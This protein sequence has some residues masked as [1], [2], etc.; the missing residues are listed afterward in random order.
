[1]NSLS[2]VSAFQSCNGT[3][4]VINHDPKNTELTKFLS[5][6][7]VWHS[8]G[9][10]KPDGVWFEAQI[11]FFDLLYSDMFKA[12]LFRLNAVAVENKAN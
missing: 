8:R 5:Y 1:M 12:V 3:T 6:F 7:D 11:E 9:E 10:F 4:F 2:K